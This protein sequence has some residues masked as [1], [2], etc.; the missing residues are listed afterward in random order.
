VTEPGEQLILPPAIREEIVAHARG[1][2]PRE[3][4][5]V[6]AGRVG[7][8]TQLHRLTNVEPGVSRYLFD[9]EEFYRVYW[10]IENR[11]ETLLAVY[12]SHPVTVAFPSKTDVEFAFWP[13]AVYVICS[14]EVPEEPAIRG[15]RIVDGEISEIEIG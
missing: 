3:C 8:P 2:A 5:G 15:F 14:L 9:D 10:E 4:C 7:A 6:I 12:H 1:Y 13:D 11:G